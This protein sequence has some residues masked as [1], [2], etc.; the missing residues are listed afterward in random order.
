MEGEIGVFCFL[1][2]VLQK[3]QEDVLC[4]ESLAEKLVQMVTVVISN[5]MKQYHHGGGEDFFL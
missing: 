4:F 1:V 5:H 3:K 2:L